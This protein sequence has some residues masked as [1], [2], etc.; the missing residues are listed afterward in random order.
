MPSVIIRNMMKFCLFLLF[1]SNLL[2]AEDKLITSINFTNLGESG[3]GLPKEA[4]GTYPELKTWALFQGMRI[5][6][7]DKMHQIH[8]GICRMI[9]PEGIKFYLETNKELKKKLFLYLDFTTYEADQEST[10]PTRRLSI[11][12]KNKLI[13]TIFFQPGKVEENPTMIIVTPDMVDNGRIN[14]ELV[15]D[16]TEGGTFWGIWDAFYSTKKEIR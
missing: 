14:I 4:F 15:P 16:Y 5:K 1:L 3:K 9:P 13:K 12:I 11:Y 10:Y 6:K 7:D 2:L 8:D